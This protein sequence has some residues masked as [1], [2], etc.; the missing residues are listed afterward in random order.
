VFQPFSLISLVSLLPEGGKAFVAGLHPEVLREW[1]DTLSGAPP[2]EAAAALQGQLKRIRVTNNLRGSLKALDIIAEGTARVSGAF[3]AEL[4][5]AQHPLSNALQDKVVAGNELL[6][7][8]ARCYRKVVDR[9][10][11]SWIGRGNAG[12]LQHALTQAMTMER[13]RLLL[14]FR[15]YS[16]GSKS[17]WRN[18]HKL[19]RLA[20]AAGHAA[21]APAGSGD[22]PD[23]IYVKTLLLALAEPVR[24]A[25]DELDR[26]RFYLDRHAGLAG[27][28]DAPR[29]VPGHDAREGCFL[30]RLSEEGP[31]RSLQKWHDFDIQSGDL[32]LDCGPLLA[33]LR[34]QVDALSGGALPSKIGLPTAA[35]RPQYLAM[36]RNLLMLWSAPPTRRFT[37]QHFRPRVEITVGLGDLWSLLSSPA[38][39]RRRDD[40]APA[41]EATTEPEL[42]QW[43]VVNES[44]AGFALQYLCGV[45]NSLSVSALVGL[46]SQDRDKVHVCLVRR[47]VS[48]GQRRAELGLQKYAAS[49]VPTMIAWDG[50][51]AAN[52]EP[53]RAIVL[54]SVPSLDGAA[55][56]IVAPGL[57]RP[58]K[59]VPYRLGD[60]NMTMIAGAPIER[61]AAYEIFSLGSPD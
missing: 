50:P 23:G 6:K 8:Q 28:L 17:A 21:A 44:P 36:M 40:R 34:S 13:R 48:G 19:H 20:R 27:L 2:E 54:P 45:S 39:K 16:P 51:A 14:A 11:G 9:L 25:P 55:A 31:G 7:Q 38:L 22:S 37:R 32:M 43:S 60:K 52:R 57:L 12:Q 24:M 5:R 1:I 49:A 33:K 15:A 35:R 59:R 47:L 56:V 30:I 18:L 26:V 4:N 3:E 41:A 29:S 61:C 46:R 53:A 10:S 42:S 58:G